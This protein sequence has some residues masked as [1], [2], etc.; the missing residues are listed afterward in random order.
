MA[1]QAHAHKISSDKK[2]AKGRTHA[3]IRAMS[4]AN[5]HKNNSAIFE[6]ISVIE[7]I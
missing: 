7:I 2:N 4:D 5:F 3:A 6:L 1:A